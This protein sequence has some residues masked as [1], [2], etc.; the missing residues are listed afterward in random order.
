VLV[1]LNGIG[2]HRNGRATSLDCVSEQT[3][4]IVLF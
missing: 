1:P 4:D 2:A 3:E